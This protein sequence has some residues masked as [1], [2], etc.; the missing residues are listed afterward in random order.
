MTQADWVKE[1]KKLS[2]DSD[3]WCGCYEGDLDGNFPK[4]QQKVIDFISKVELLAQQRTEKKWREKSEGLKKIVEYNIRKQEAGF[5]VTLRMYNK[6][7][8]QALS[9][10]NN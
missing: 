1:Y 7:Y 2:P 5:D 8:L 4:Q 9:D 10:L 3:P 6:G